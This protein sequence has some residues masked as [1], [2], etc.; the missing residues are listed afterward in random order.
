M[1]TTNAE[2]TI[3]HH[4]YEDKPDREA[5]M[6]TAEYR[7]HVAEMVYHLRYRKGLSQAAF[8]ARVGLTAEVIAAVEE[9]D[10]RVDDLPDLFQKIQAGFS[11]KKI[12]WGMIVLKSIVSIALLL[13]GYWFPSAALGCGFVYLGIGLMV[14]CLHDH[15]ESI[16][17][18]RALRRV[19]L[20]WPGVVIQ[21][22]LWRH[23]DP[24]NV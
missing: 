22:F 16:H 6:T 4:V 8:A 12:N 3:H 21:S 11:W 9:S 14:A 24:W 18:W 2:A 20:G 1:T 17:D 5:A 7:G 23:L 10:Y 15:D 19:I 13:A